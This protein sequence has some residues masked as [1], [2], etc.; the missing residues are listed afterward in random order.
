MTAGPKLQVHTST[1]HSVRDRATSAHQDEG[2]FLALDM[3][4]WRGGVILLGHGNVGAGER[5]GSVFASMNSY[6]LKMEQHHF[7]MNPI[8][9]LSSAETQHL[10]YR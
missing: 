6:K 5:N 2:L 9:R 8:A 3:V 4:G 10:M 7:S 1:R